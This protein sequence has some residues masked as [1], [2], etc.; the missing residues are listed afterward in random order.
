MGEDFA[1]DIDDQNLLASVFE[2]RA[3]HLSR[4]ELN[5]STQNTPRSKEI[6]AKLKGP[7]AKLLSGPRG[8][9]KST[10]LRRAFFD[11]LETGDVLPV[12]VNYARS[13]A[14]EPLFHHRANAL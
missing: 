3:E 2:E 6:L 1:P 8:C 10:Y 13:L 4:S 5:A 11:L 9:G 14:L 7:R 12:Y